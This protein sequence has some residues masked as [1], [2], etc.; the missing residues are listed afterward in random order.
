MRYFSV[1][2]ESQFFRRYDTNFS[3]Y[4]QGE[5]RHVKNSRNQK[6]KVVTSMNVADKQNAC[7]GEVSG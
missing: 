1:L 4:E 5:T 3:R 2:Y 6:V 7:C